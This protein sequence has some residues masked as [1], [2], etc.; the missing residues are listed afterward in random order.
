MTIASIGAPPP[1]PPARSSPEPSGATGP[2]GTASGV[3]FASGSLGEPGRSAPVP[4]S[5]GSFG[6]FPSAAGLA[7]FGFSPAFWDEPAKL[8]SLHAARAKAQR[9]MRVF[10]Q[11]LSAGLVKFMIG[12]PPRGDIL[13]KW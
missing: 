6:V 7:A 12:A 11:T 5:F 13:M 8:L 1:S 9:R 10:M 3:F 4:G 2:L